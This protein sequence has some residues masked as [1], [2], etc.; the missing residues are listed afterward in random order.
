M[1]QPHVPETA[2]HTIH[3]LL[4]AKTQTLSTILEQLDT[5]IDHRRQLATRHHDILSQHICVVRSDL[6]Q[7]ESSED[8]HNPTRRRTLEDQ[9]FRLHAEH[10]HEAVACWQDLAQLRAERRRWW[11]E[12]A[13]LHLRTRL[14]RYPPSQ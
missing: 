6:T 1:T 12:Y 8:R 4:A 11:K 9:L 10:R 5:D 2:R 14:L 3:S 7:L 13:E